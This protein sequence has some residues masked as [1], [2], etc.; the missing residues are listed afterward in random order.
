[1]KITAIKYSAT[2]QRI[3]ELES[4]EEI[5]A[6][7]E[8]KFVLWIDITNPTIEELSPLKSL[9]GFHSLAI[10]NSVQVEERP[11]M[12]DYD[13]YL[14]VRAKTINTGEE[15][16]STGQLSIFVCKYILITI[17]EKQLKGIEEIKER[18]LR[19]KP[20]ILKGKADF[21]LYRILYAIVDNY[22]SVIEDFEDKMDEI[23]EEVLENP[24]VRT[25]EKIRKL[26]RQI[27]HIHRII[28]GQRDVVDKLERSDTAIIKPETKIYFRDVYD[29]TSSLL[30]S[31]DN[32]QGNAEGA[33]EVYH[34]SLANKMNE[35]M[36]MLTTIATIFIPLT[37]L[38][39]VYGMN[40]RY[41]PELEWRWGYFTAL[42]L[43][44]VIAIGMVIYV[45]KKKWL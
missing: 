1:M 34:S 45:R 8:E 29:H 23:D 14:F 3:Y 22:I 15:G 18:I 35:I 21:L 17:H 24:T 12:D 11:K 38:V 36:K 9:F 32:I 31:M 20:L 30:D 7:Q 25:I 2:M 44:V 39:G 42:F 6:L 5:P 33:L 37:F 43:M 19:K 28:R 27:R 10:E 16:I 26:I 41:M 4:L 13:E 40:F